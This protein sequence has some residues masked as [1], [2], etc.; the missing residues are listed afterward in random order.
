MTFFRKL[1][2]L[3]QRRRKE[4]ELREELQFHLDEEAAERASDGLTEDEARWAAHRELGNVTRVQESVRDVWISTLWEH[5]V[6]DLRYATRMILANKTFSALAIVSLALGIG[7]NS[8]LY[9]FMDSILLRSLPVSGPDS[10]LILQWHNQPR[11]HGNQRTPTV[12]HSLS[13]TTY[14]DSK[15]GEVAGIFPYPAFELFR[16]ND[17]LFSNVFAY[18]SARELNVLVKGQASVV[19]G[20]YV[21]GDYFGGLGVLPVAGRMIIPADDDSAAPVVAVVSSRFSQRNFGAADASGK[22]ILINSVPTLVVGT[23]PPDFFGV[24]PGDSPDVYL[25]VHASVSIE[26]ALPF[27]DGPERFLDQNDYWIEV[28]ARLRPGVTREQAQVALAPQFHEWVESTATTAEERETLPA[29]VVQQGGT[30]VETLRRRYSQPLWILMALAGLILAIA[31]ANIANLL[32]ARATSRRTEIAVRLS[33]GAARLRLIRQLLTESVLLAA[34]GG[35]LGL[36]VAIWGMRAL[37]AMLSNG[38]SDFTLGARLNWH[39]LGVAVALSLLTGILF[40]L[41]PA[42]Q[43][44]RFD[45]LPALKKVRIDASGARTR[46]SL[47][48]VLVVAQI[49]LSL[50]MLVAAGLFARTLSNLQSVELGFNRDN[51]L[52]FQLDGAKAG[53]KAPEISAFYGDLTQRFSAIPGVLSAT[54]SHESLIDAGSGLPIHLPGAPDDPSTR[55]LSVGPGFFQTMQIPIVAGR[56]IEERDQPGSAKVAVISELFARNNFSDQ[57]PLGRHLILENDG[58]VRDM[59]IVGVAR[60][61]H[62]GRLDHK[63]PP[64]VYIAYN[65]GYPPP[66]SMTYE[67]RTSMNPVTCLNTVREIVHQ[68]DARVP[69]TDVRTQV[70]DIDKTISQEITFARLCTGF[71]VLALVIACIGLYATVSYKVAGRTGEIGIRLAL[72]APRGA[73]VWMVLREVVILATVGLAISVPVALSSARLIQA[74]LFEMRPN[75]PQALTVAGAILLTA[76]LA[77][78]YLP[79]RKAARIDPMIALRHE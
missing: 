68:A 46:P 3:A 21:S 37:T 48:R 39:V 42:L 67:L 32:L 72:G 44:T 78:G 4:T 25:P 38:Q 70:A 58:N 57:N 64:V 50:V 17:Q 18:H 7:A 43:S 71:A 10:L 2:W 22:T 59:Q 24:D 60:T 23:A 74:F 51:L 13:G 75:D 12:L 69:V 66:R 29:L 49:A 53:H 73:V 35:M 36:L 40:G 79:A 15:L 77:A 63:T 45:V 52:L 30:G 34:L 5:F 28:M 19:R 61:A 47:S 14:D 33:L 6:Q 1:T 56:G 11:W 41:A 65:Q 9:S 31:C 8:A 54:L 27:G 62:Y 55:Y 26:A 20:E 16:K 76:V